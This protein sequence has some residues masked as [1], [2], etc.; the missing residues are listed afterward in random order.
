MDYLRSFFIIWLVDYLADWLC[1]SL[2][3]T[4]GC[5]DSLSIVKSVCDQTDFQEMLAEPNGNWT[6]YTNYTRTLRIPNIRYRTYCVSS[7]TMTLLI[8]KGHC[9]KMDYFEVP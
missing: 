2:G 1:M 5:L 9:H 8:L 3:Q 7:V 6:S 4:I